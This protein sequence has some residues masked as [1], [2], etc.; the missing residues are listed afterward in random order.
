MV[1]NNKVLEE[2]TLNSWFKLLTGSLY[3]CRIVLSLVNLDKTQ[4]S[5]SNRSW[6]WKTFRL[7]QSRWS[8]HP[9]GM[10][11]GRKKKIKNSVPAR[12]ARKR[13][14]WQRHKHVEKSALETTNMKASCQTPTATRGSGGSG[15]SGDR[16]QLDE[17]GE[18]GPHL[19]RAHPLVPTPVSAGGSH[20]RRRETGGGSGRA[21]GAA[22]LPRH[23]LMRLQ[24]S[25]MSSAVRGVN[26]GGEGQNF[27][28]PKCAVG[29]G[30][31]LG[32][33]KQMI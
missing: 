9:S 24:A 7:F 30:E 21:S 26:C 12:D 19:S 33:N 22:T 1:L 8:P 18:R 29:I 28:S 4:D 16:R 2:K 31:S 10:R 27:S 3:M 15:A 32:N 11:S 20:Q 17:E 5:I 6:K 14:C 25:L 23:C 13:S